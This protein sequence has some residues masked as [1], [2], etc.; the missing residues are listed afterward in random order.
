MRITKKMLR[1]SKSLISY[2]VKEIMGFDDSKS[3]LEFKKVFPTVEYLPDQ[4]ILRRMLIQNVVDN[5]I[6]SHWVD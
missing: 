4:Y 2:H 5:A 3:E 6:P 1:E